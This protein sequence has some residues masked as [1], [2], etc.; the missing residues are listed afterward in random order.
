[1]LFALTFIFSIPGFSSTSRFSTTPATSSVRGADTQIQLGALC[2]I[3]LAIS[4]I[5]TAVVL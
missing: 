1:M 5:G 3:L 4:N 2:E